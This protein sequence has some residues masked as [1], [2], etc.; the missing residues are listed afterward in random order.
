[1]SELEQ[2]DI[3]KFFDEEFD[4]KKFIG[5]MA[6]IEV[7]GAK[8]YEALAERAGNQEVKELF[9]F[10]AGE[11][12]QHIKDFKTL[13]KVLEKELAP[14]ESCSLEEKEFLRG[15]VSSHSF[16]QKGAA[17][18]VV[19]GPS[20]TN[21]NLSQVNTAREALELALRF[22]RDSIMVFQE[23]ENYVCDAG[24]EILKDLIA[25]EKGHVRK[26]MRHFKEL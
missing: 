18:A 10:L 13:A 5:I 15:I 23:I 17:D 4:V 16:F 24:R 26:L 21:I 19:M 25:Q 7:K 9:L 20:F 1:M 2:I 14:G 3:R 12:K 8:F 11:E 22:E 6:A